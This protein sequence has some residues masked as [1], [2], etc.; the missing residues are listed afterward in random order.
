[1]EK[2]KRHLPIPGRTY[3]D[4]GITYTNMGTGHEYGGTASTGL[5]EPFI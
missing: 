4:A 2:K 3:A 5:C 1:M